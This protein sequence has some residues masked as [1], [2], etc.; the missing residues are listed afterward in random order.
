MCLFHILEKMHE[1]SLALKIV[2]ILFYRFIG[3]KKYD[4]K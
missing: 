4:V 1:S 3:E 2:L